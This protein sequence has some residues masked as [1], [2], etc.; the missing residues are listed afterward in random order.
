MS[1]I[2]NSPEQADSKDTQPGNLP[3]D[4][5]NGKD[6]SANTVESGIV[7][8][9]DLQTPDP[10]R[11]KGVTPASPPSG[12]GTQEGKT[13]QHSAALS[14][15]C[16]CKSPPPGQSDSDPSTGSHDASRHT[17]A[18]TS[19]AGKGHK[20]QFFMIDMVLLMLCG[21][22]LPVITLAVELCTHMCGEIY[23]NPIPTYFHVALIA[24]VPFGNFLAWRAMRRG[25]SDHFI[26]LA[27]I[28]G[29]TIG[30]SMFYA[31]IFLPLIPFA[32]FAVIFFGFGLLPLS[33]VYSFICA[34][35]VALQLKKLDP[36]GCTTS[37]T[38]FVLLGILLAWLSMA[39][40]ELPGFM[41]HIGLTQAV[42]AGSPEK[43]RA[44]IRILRAFGCEQAILKDCYDHSATVSDLPGLMF[45][46]Y[47][48]INR[49]EARNIYYR[50]TGRPFNSVPRPKI[51]GFTGFD[52]NW[53]NNWD[54]EVAG[55]Q[56]GGRANGVSLAASSIDG[57]LMG[58]AAVGY[59]E[60]TMTFQNE[61]Q[62][63]QEAR[64][65]IALPPGSVVS[66][67]S[68]WINGVPVD[69]VFG[70]KGVVR[71]AYQAVVAKKRDPLLVTS[72]GP[73]R[74]L[75]Q[76]F[77][78][79]P[80]NSETHQAGEMKVRIGIT[81][82]L[83]LETKDK[84]CLFLPH[85]LENNFAVK[86]VH[87]IRLLS[88]SPLVTSLSALKS[89]SGAPTCLTGTLSEDGLSAPGLY[90]NCR[91]CPEIGQYWSSAPL[92]HN[93][94]FLVEK[95]QE[96]TEQPPTH[97]AIVVDGSKVMGP[98]MKAIAQSLSHIH[99]EIKAEVFF[100]SDEIS[101]LSPEKSS[102]HSAS[103][104]S[105][106][107]DLLLAPC[108]GGPDNVPALLEACKSAKATPGGAIV[109]I[110]GPQ[111]VL[112]DP[113]TE[114]LFS[115]RKGTDRPMLYDVEVK[116]GP[117]RLAEAI[118]KAVDLQPITRRKQSLDKDLEDIFSGWTG[119]R[120]SYKFVRLKTD[121]QPA[122]P[123]TTAIEPCAQLSTLFTF[124]QTEKLLAAGKDEEAVRLASHSRLV[125]P[126]TGAVVLETKQQY[127]ANGLDPDNPDNSST[128]PSFHGFNIS[129][130]PE[131]HEW[132]LIFI[133]A[134]V[135][136]LT[137]CKRRFLARSRA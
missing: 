85:L 120:K 124:Q 46:A 40:L 27:L 70:Q 60:W 86:G 127:L 108:V 67:V 44:G 82:P 2:D 69:A 50:V 98:H 33:P 115:D 15:P 42:A 59:L 84:T 97:I 128:K 130:A 31:L 81:V 100:A 55:E 89:E 80:A 24:L 22:I 62:S 9:Q 5:H 129:A 113:S 76:C 90:I 134:G 132:C 104:D 47:N 75:L 73:N 57:S 51:A 10:S 119:L 19:S 66:R 12:Q 114:Y 121:S 112:F 23:V 78:V 49:E 94:T 131:P 116:S 43:N 26:R 72:A 102:S 87:N 74:V 41:A 133:A 35:G 8:S 36:A 111:P 38:G 6:Q 25:R 88:E 16:W 58:D 93:K 91:R 109:W 105:A 122:G 17:G 110:H 18:K 125:T 48:Y 37:A 101:A 117:N 11:E 126:V 63:Q 71:Q 135:L 39:A 56:V 28:N 83:V 92:S 77:P 45:G 95:V 21:I 137:I 64:T 1:D 3:V 68:L 13:H 14:A 96:T 29:V 136:F 20:R 53:F 61:S 7:S 32:M 103:L 118:Q 123:G 4:P 107:R 106:R 52:D 30:I 65:Q 54:P 99:P 34:V 79:P